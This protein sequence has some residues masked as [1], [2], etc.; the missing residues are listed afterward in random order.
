MTYLL[1][2]LFSICE[3]FKRLQTFSRLL[4]KEDSTFNPLK[5]KLCISKSIEQA[6]ITRF[7]LQKTP[8]DQLCYKNIFCEF[9]P[10][11]NHILKYIMCIVCSPFFRYNCDEAFASLSLTDQWLALEKTID[12]RTLQ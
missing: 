4:F 12:K 9:Q 11:S 8:D 6:P 3:P 7:R 2:W 10:L 1:V 5:S